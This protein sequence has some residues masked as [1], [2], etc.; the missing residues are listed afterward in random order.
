MAVVRWV[1]RF[2]IG[3]MCA[4]TFVWPFVLSAD[5]A[6]PPF[7]VAAIATLLVFLASLVALL[8]V[9]LSRSNPP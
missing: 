8:T 9:R 1:F 2:S 3:A 6:H 5:P 7:K 4:L